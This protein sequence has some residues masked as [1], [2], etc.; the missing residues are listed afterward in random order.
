[1]DFKTGETARFRR[2]LTQED[3]N[4]FAA[5]SKDDNPIHVDPLFAAKS[6]FGA[7]VS[8]GMLLYSLIAK[9]L[10]ELIPG[11]GAVQ[12]EQELMFPNGTYTGEEISV[13]L[14]V[15]AVHPD[16][17]LD[18]A[19]MV[20]KAEDPSNVKVQGRALVLPSGAGVLREAKPGSGETG[21]E[22][23]YGLS[24]GMFVQEKRAF[25]DKDLAEYGNLS[26]DRNP[27]FRDDEYAKAR[28]FPGRIVPWPLLG[29]MFSD[30]LGTRLPG[31]GTGWMK[32]KLIYPGPA[33]PGEELLARV[34]ITRL[35]PDKELVNLRSTI[36]A[37]GRPVCDGESLVLVRNLE[38]KNDKGSG[39]GRG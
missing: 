29:G 3:F 35:R 19:T 18:V 7:T 21:G 4:R 36:T 33:Y 17:S 24:V 30:M 6:H 28:G 9:G 1:M 13:A 12:L 16:G 27:L 31:R 37:N 23:F 32:Q 11:P 15:T 14:S 2:I 34:E 5:L 22:A 39:F 10:S 8:H 26:G 38:N 20:T 25:T